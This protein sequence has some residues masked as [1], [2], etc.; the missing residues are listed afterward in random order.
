[1]ITCYIGVGTNIDRRKH[2]EQAV[3][4]LSQIGT[5]LRLSSIYECAAVGFD[6]HP[7]YNLVI[8]LQTD[9]SLTL[10]LQELRSIEL[11]CG[12]SIDAEKFQDRT[13][14]LDVLLFGDYVSQTQP[15]LPRRDIYHYP[16]VLQPL[17]ELCPE[18]IIPND[19]RTVS[20]LWQSVSSFQ[21]LTQVELWFNPDYF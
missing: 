5:S 14:D 13:I 9:R 21:L 2:I 16:F 15:E 20:E 17:Y 19:G 18:L 3:R 7:F 10:F 6:S 12:R 8:E 11:K 4:E 1:M